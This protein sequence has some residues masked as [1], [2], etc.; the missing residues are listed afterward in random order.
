[1][2]IQIGEKPAPTFAAPLELLSDCHRRI[3]RFLD[4][5]LLVTAQAG[6]GP[7]TDPQREA[8]E[9]ALR[10]FRE[11]A[12]KHTED[13]ED[14]LFPRLRAAGGEPVRKALAQI[15]AL[16]AD[17]RE[18]QAAHA[19]VERLGQTWLAEN[20]LLPADLAALSQTLTQL[21]AVYARHIRV[22]DE[23]IFPLAGRVLDKSTLHHVGAEMAARRGQKLI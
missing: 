6:G 14:S 16:E 3:E 2:P 22:E 20:R 10:Y 23:E 5:L 21:R 18:A 13:E 19:L 4:L 7:L 9:T 15:E 8:F 17:H 11:A 12:P 1:M